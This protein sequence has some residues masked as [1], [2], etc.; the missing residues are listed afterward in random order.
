M[1][2][3]AFSRDGTRIVSGSRDKTL[4]LWDA[5]SSQ[6]IRPLQG[7]KYSVTSVAFS[8][9]GTRTVSGSDD[10][11]LRLWDAKSGQPIGAQ[12]QGHKFRVTSVAFSPDGTRIV[13]RMRLYGIE[14][15]K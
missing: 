5:K 12:L 3:V 11:T 10:K 8:P 2:S 9:D 14:R 6:P 4:R 7:H 15:R 1:N 13:R